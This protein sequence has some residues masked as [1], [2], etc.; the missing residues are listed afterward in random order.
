MFFS[1]KAALGCHMQGLYRMVAMR[2]GLD[3]LGLS[4]VLRTMI[5]W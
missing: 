3:K 4:G 1:D 5:L 2:D